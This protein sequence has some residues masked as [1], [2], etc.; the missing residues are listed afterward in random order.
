MVVL[1][2][3]G[4]S[5]GR[6]LLPPEVLER[7][8][9]RNGSADGNGAGRT[10]KSNVSRLE[11]RMIAEAPGAQRLEQ[12]RRGARAR[13]QLPDAAREDP[14]L[15]DRARS[16]Q[17]NKSRVTACVDALDIRPGRFC[18]RQARVSQIVRPLLLRLLIRETPVP[19]SV[20]A[21]PRNP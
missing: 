4:D 20:T 2:D 11:K 13:A 15:Q 9:N 7:R 12:G 14:H 6:D 18:V 5:L 10:L 8:P 3:E 21:R 17:L 1:A 19:V 16:E